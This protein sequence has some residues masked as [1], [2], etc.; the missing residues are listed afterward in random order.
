M[1]TL[2]TSVYCDAATPW[3]FGFQDPATPVMQGIIH[4]H[5]DIMFFDV[6]VLA[7]VLWMLVRTL[8]LFRAREGHIPTKIIH[9][10]AIEIAWTVTPSLILLAIAVP[11]FALLYSMDENI[12]PAIT[13][14]AIGHQ[15]YWT[16]EYSD[17]SSSE[18]ES[19]VFDSYMVAEDDLEKGQ[20]RLLEVDNR[21]VVP[22]HTH[23]RLLLTS[24]DVLHSWAVPSLGVKCDAIPG[25]LNQT[26]FYLLREGIF[27]GQCS[28]LCGINHGFMPIVVEGVTL[29][30]YVQWVAEKADEM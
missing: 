9:G 6:G 1:Y 18:D 26:G 2:L 27:Y 17:Y 24:A 15:W 29:D 5:H 13:V 7:F 12:D 3:Q 11:S 14:K 19:I 28:E 25:R 10:T 30:Q 23:I 8:W 20:L 21:V 22:V 16:Y 4:L